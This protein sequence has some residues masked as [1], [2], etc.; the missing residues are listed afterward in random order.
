MARIEELEKE[1]AELKSRLAQNSNNSN[2]PPSSDGLKK[3]P[4]FPRKKGK[5]TGGQKGHKGRTLEMVSDPDHVIKHA[6]VKCQCGQSLKRVVKHTVE[7]R[8]IFDLPEPKLEVTE[9][10]LQGCSCPNCSRVNVG[11]FPVEVPARVQYGNG[12]RALSVLLNTGLNMPLGKVRQFFADIF[13]Y[14]LNDSTQL[15]AHQK[16][17]DLTAPSENQLRQLLLDSQ[18]NHFDETGLRVGGRL[19][20][21][22]NC[23][24]D[25][26]TY[27]FVHPNRGRKALDS[28]SSLLPFYTGWSVHD[29]WSSYFRYGNTKHAICGAHLLRE[30]QGLKEQGS[31]WAGLMSGLLLYAYEKSNKGTAAAADPT[32]I[33]RHYD[34]ICKLADAEEPKA[35]QRFKHKRPKR[36]KGRNLLG[37][38]VKYKP[39]VLAFTNHEFVPFTNNQAERDIRPAKIKLKNAGSFRTLKGARI[40]AR[41][42]S[43]ISTSRK[44]Q[45]NVFNELVAIF[46][47]NSFLLSPEKC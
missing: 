28:P 13:G 40:Y 45:L 32:F 18:V 30:L 47:G 33:E 5:K 20:W 14:D 37:R 41:I 10:Q 44:H 17:Y 34:R 16:C 25:K 19:H 35:Q 31:K 46:N 43:F 4:A 9:H 21:L 1:N 38:L 11:E 3:R 29:C 15:S 27:L 22:H 39:A 8:Q 26:Y 36:T 2:R 6:P 12:V 23:S 42:Q 7:R 24:N